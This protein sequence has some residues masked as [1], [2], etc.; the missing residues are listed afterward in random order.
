MVRH[1]V[2]SFNAILLDQEEQKQ[3]LLQVIEKHR[4]VYPN[5]NKSTIIIENKLA[6]C[7]FQVTKNVIVM[8]YKTLIELCFVF[9]FVVVHFYVTF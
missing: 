4:Q 2:K 8:H 5:T 1:L 3:F 7:E 6:H 9:K